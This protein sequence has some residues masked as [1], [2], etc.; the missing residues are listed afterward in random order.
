MKWESFVPIE[1][2]TKR[3]P[4][5]ELIRKS[6]YAGIPPELREIARLRLEN[7][8]MTLRDLSENLSQP[9][10]RSGVNHRLKK[11]MELAEE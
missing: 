7:P 10:T 2:S 4:N 6:G 9:I 5:S 8:E 3:F 1:P 11:L